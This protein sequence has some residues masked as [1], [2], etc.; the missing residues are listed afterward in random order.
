[1]FGAGGSAQ[2]AD[3]EKAMQ[4]LNVTGTQTL[5]DTTLSGAPIKRES[6]ETMVRSL[7]YNRENMQIWQDIPKQ[8]VWNN[9]N[10]RINQNSFGSID[11][12]FVGEGE[13]GEENDTIFERKAEPVRYI[14]EVRRVTEQMMAIQTA[15]GLADAMT[16]Q[17]EAGLMTILARTN[18]NIVRANNTNVGHEWNGLYAQHRSGAALSTYLASDQIIDMRGAVL[19][20]SSIT[21]A[22]RRVVD[23]Y[24][25]IDSI[26]APP[27]VIDGYVEQFYS[28][29]RNII[30]A[31]DD[32][33]LGLRATK[34]QTQFGKVGLKHD[35]FLNPIKERIKQSGSGSTSASAPPAPTAGG[36]PTA[37]NASAANSMFIAGDAGSYLYAVTAYNS[38]G[39]SAPTFLGTA[40][41]VSAADG[42]DLSFTE[43]TPVAGRATEAFR[44]YRTKKNETVNFHLIAEVSKAE[45]V[46]G[47]DG[48]SANEFRDLNRYIAGTYQAFACW[49]NKQ[50]WGFNQLLPISKKMLAQT[51]LSIPFAVYM[52]GNPMLYQPRKFVRFINVGA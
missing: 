44:I 30:P 28:D 1:M 36:T 31:S 40:V 34:V 20:K 5:N 27:V 49:N 32:T 39:E 33:T 22:A 46:A 38:F 47:Y 26:Y 43:G 9:V 45:V 48:G 19:S 18:L 15:E 23:V 25:S 24:G 12:G 8:R 13:V 41:T 14:V 3:L 2:F 10:E 16:I 17:T 37:V 50:V 42:I 7:E 51:S 6:L 21:E 4:A 35:V 29:N 11:G 52:F